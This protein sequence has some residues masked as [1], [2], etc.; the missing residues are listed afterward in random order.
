MSTW[1]G[2]THPYKKMSV[3]KISVIHSQCTML[4]VVKIW[5]HQLNYL[6]QKKSDHRHL[7]V[8]QY[9]GENPTT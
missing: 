6:Q 3:Y 8:W 7:K 4:L 5:I 2:E 1:N 9:F